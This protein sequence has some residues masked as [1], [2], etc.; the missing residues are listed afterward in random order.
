MLVIRDES[1]A[2]LVLG[3]RRKDEMAGLFLVVGGL[4]V[5][6]VLLAIL[7]DRES[8]DVD[9][10]VGEA[11]FPIGMYGIP[12]GLVGFV[13]V[14][15]QQK[16]IFDRNH[17]VVARIRPLRS[18]QTWPLASLVEIRIEQLTPTA[19][20]LQLDFGTETITVGTGGLLESR[21]LA[22]SLRRFTGVDPE[23]SVARS[24]GVL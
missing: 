3:P 2:R 22:K 19:Y 18:T 24:Q 23:R 15:L 17:G 4:V 11:L 7:V 21:E 16:F 12:L 6:S 9:R 5:V 13:V 20:K 8:F 14:F 1:D 10:D